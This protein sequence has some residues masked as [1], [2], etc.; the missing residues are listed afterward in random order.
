MPGLRPDG[1]P[2]WGETD[3]KRNIVLFAVTAGLLLSL[4][5][6]A[7]AQDTEGGLNTV[8]TPYY[9]L[10]TDLSPEGIAEVRQRITRMAEEYNA[11]TQG[12]GGSV[13]KRLPVFVVSTLAAFQRLGGQAGAAGFYNGQALVVRADSGISPETWHIVQHEGFH[14]FADAAIG[15]LLPPWV[16][17]GLAEYF[18]YGQ[19]TGDAFY[20][21]FVPPRA[22][23]KVRFAL[24]Q[25]KMLPFEKLMEMDLPAW[26]DHVVAGD[27]MRAQINYVQ[28]WAMVQFL[29]HGENGKYQQPF[30]DFLNAV[31]RK[32]RWLPAWINIFGDDVEAFEQRFR[33]YWMAM[34][35]NPTADLEAQATVATVTSFYARAA[36]QRQSFDTFEE[37]L[38]AAKAGTLAQH[39]DD[40][41]PP[42]LLEAALKNLE[43]TGTW[44][45]RRRSPQAVLC[46]RPD[47]TLL[48]GRFQF[49]GP[50]VK[51]TDVVVK[52]AKKRRP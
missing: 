10:H 40:W 2:V 7:R 5:A 36:R 47:G 21:G 42:G 23:A 31:A 14:Q 16:N 32:Q 18:G 22:L 19:F 13:N 50:R 20:T 34:G 52:S 17:E 11:R 24:E 49:D 27:G 29:A 28:A 43:T 8:E 39:E 38:A 44:S 45:L 51:S 4:A 12:F 6:P 35:E 30:L 33:E 48:E 26:N 25:N 1:L 9:T 3:V 37:F 15:D 41:L 46:E